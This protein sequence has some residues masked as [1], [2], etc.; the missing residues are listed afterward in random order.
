V[1][2]SSAQYG[3]K[4]GFQ[5]S[6]AF[7]GSSRRPFGAGPKR[8]ILRTGEGKRPFRSPPGARGG[9]PFRGGKPGWKKKAGPRP[10]RKF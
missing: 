9:G 4:A 6:G 1:F 2:K 8:E 10:F 3:L 7:P 5:K